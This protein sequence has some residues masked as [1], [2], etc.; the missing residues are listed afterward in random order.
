MTHRPLTRI[1]ATA[2][3][4]L[5][6]AAC[7]DGGDGPRTDPPATVTLASSESEADDAASDGGGD[8]VDSKEPEGSETDA[9][10][11]PAPDPADYPGMDENTPEGAEQAFRYFIALT[12]WGFQTG[13]TEELEGLYLDSCEACSGNVDIMRD[14]NQDGEYWTSVTLEE[15]VDSVSSRVTGGDEDVVVSYGIFVSAHS[16]PDLEAGGVVD[17]GRSDVAFGAGL[18][19]MEGKWMVVGM[20]TVAYSA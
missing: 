11:V 12:F 9:A 16:E 18:S 20:D 19:W 5:G 17:V 13:E 10:A 8:A 6:L 4:A 15:R 3:L 7:G 14:F 2:I 1:A